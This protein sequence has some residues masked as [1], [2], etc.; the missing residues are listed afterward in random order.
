MLLHLSLDNILPVTPQL[1]F[2]KV[3]FFFFPPDMSINVNGA[4]KLVNN[5]DL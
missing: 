4:Y 2:I 3:A 5:P 1:N